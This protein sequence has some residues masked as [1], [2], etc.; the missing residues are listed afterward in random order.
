MCVYAGSISAT[1][2]ALYCNI[3]LNVDQLAS[4][5][6]RGT[7]HLS[8][9]FYFHGFSLQKAQKRYWTAAKCGSG[10]LSCF[11]GSLT[12]LLPSSLLPRR[13][14]LTYLIIRLDKSVAF[15]CGPVR[16]CSSVIFQ[17]T[18]FNQNYKVLSE[19]YI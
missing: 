16:L 19:L 7:N 15:V 13:D 6:I 5:I 3:F 17:E 9:G 14:K 4:S 12:F 8:A 10:Y 2:L 1:L 18:I 11:E